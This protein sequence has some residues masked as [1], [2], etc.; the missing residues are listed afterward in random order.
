MGNT[1]N[2]VSK[3]KLSLTGVS[4]IRIRWHSCFSGGRVERDQAG[5]R[6]LG[7]LYSDK[8]RHWGKFKKWICRTR[9]GTGVERREK[10]RGKFEFQSL[11]MRTGRWS[12]KGNRKG[13]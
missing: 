1:E 13:L 9:W 4:C 5:I 8:D 12:W 3:K 10:V 11:R 7:G 2:L 6:P